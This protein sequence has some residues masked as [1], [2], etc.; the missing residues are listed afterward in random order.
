MHNDIWTGKIASASSQSQ[1][2][3][4]SW[5][6]T[7]ASCC[8]RRTRGIHAALAWSGCGERCPRHN[9][10]RLDTLDTIAAAEMGSVDYGQISA[11]SVRTVLKLDLTLIWPQLTVAQR[12][13][14]MQ[15]RMVT[16]KSSRCWLQRVLIGTTLRP[17][18]QVEV[19]A[20]WSRPELTWTQPQLTQAQHPCS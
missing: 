2:E 12:P 11:R 16:S 1:C 20:C 5:W 6:Y 7:F 14:T 15:R 13:C 19:C 18:Y 17:R 3:G 8:W 10:W 9:S 4:Y